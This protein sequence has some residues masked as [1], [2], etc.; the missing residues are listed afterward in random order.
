MAKIN[1]FGIVTTA[2]V[3]LMVAKSNMD[4]LVPSAIY[5]VGTYS[6]YVCVQVNERQGEH[7]C[8]EACGC[9]TALVQLVFAHVSKPR[10]SSEARRDHQT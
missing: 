6:M 8:A 3:I 1:G 4:S 10:V 5:L 9:L 2:T 7:P